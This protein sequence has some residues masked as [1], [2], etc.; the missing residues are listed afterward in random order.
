[1]PDISVLQII[2]LTVATLAGIVIGW[3]VRGKRVRHEKA[4]LNARWKERT[5]A[6]R[7]EHKRL[8]DQNQGLME[9]VSQFQASG[10]D[11]SNRARELSTALKEAFERRD[12]LQREIKDVRGKLEAAQNERRRLDTELRHRAEADNSLQTSLREKDDKIFKLSRELES[13][14]DRL[15]PLIQRYRER[16]ADAKRLESDLDRAY[17]RILELESGRASDHTHVES[18]DRDSMSRALDASNDAGAD[19]DTDEARADVNGAPLHDGRDN[20][21]EIKG[22]G[23]VAAGQ[24]AE[25]GITTYAQVA[26]LTDED[27]V[28]IDEAM[29]FSADQ[30]K[31]W[32]EQAKELAK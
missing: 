2:L 23:P 10:K 30:I 21:K 1:M 28:R 3:L 11:A 20:L 6:Q 27:V 25:Q 9:Q 12:H 15:P 18:I 4:A 16:D 7:G 17:E 26:D 5:D 13:W 22:I 29:P 8:V 32:R 19:D 31:D 14:Q 24:L